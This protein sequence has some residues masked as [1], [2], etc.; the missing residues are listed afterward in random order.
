MYEYFLKEKSGFLS[1]KDKSRKGH[2]DKDIAKILSKIN[3]KKDYYTTS[4]CSG[5]IVLLEKL[6]NKK[7]DSR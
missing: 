1:K 2:I 5:R 7:S 3:S 4:S 6:S